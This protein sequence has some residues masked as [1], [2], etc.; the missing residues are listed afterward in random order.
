MA[1]QT[2]IVH[3]ERNKGFSNSRNPA[4]LLNWTITFEESEKVE[5]NMDR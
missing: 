1:A 2:R 5:T 3:F 4:P